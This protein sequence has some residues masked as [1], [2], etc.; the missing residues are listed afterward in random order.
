MTKSMVRIG[1]W[2]SEAAILLAAGLIVLLTSVR[3]ADAGTLSNQVVGPPVDREARTLELHAN[4]QETPPIAYS[5]RIAGEEG[6]PEGAKKE[7]AKDSDALPLPES[8]APPLSPAQQYCSNIVDATS[9]AQIAQQTKNLDKARKEIDDRIA[10][11]NAKAEVLQKWMKLREDF[12][13][14]ATDSLVQIYSKMKADSAAAQLAAMDEM[15]SAAII[16]K[17]AP[18]VSSPIMAEMAVEKAARLSAVI[19]GSGDLAIQPERKV[20]AQH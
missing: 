4:P 6:K 12:T 11:L 17:L 10:L 8:S 16:S 19:A 3:V 18:K 13:A 5:F 2:H 14:R 1:S 7:D 15:T 20:N 9:A